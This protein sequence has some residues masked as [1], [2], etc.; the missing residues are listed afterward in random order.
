MKV[1]IACKLIDEITPEDCDYIG[2]D[3]GALF[4]A[5]QGIH[6]VCAIGD[7]DSVEQEDLKL[8]HQFSREVVCL[9][10]IKDDTDAQAAIEKADSLGYQQ[11]E[12]LGATGGRIDHELINLRLTMQYPGRVILKDDRNLIMAYP[13]GT[14]HVK[15]DDYP[16]FSF[17]TQSED[18]LTLHGFAYPLERR[19]ITCYDLYTVSNQL[20]GETGTFINEKNPVLLI[21]SRDEKKDS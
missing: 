19:R 6:M 18:V 10:P 9:N 21:R 8:I 3:K 2:V 13:A 15:A 1:I 17:F 5:R 14:H 20:I 16:Y 12:I 4:L 11:M 7:F